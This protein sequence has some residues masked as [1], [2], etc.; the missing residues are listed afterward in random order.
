M[1]ASMGSRKIRVSSVRRPLR[2]T[3]LRTVHGIFSSCI[4]V[5]I[6]PSPS[7]AFG[8]SA[9]SGVPQH[10]GVDGLLGRIHPDHNEF[11]KYLGP[12]MAVN[13]GPSV[14]ACWTRQRMEMRCALGWSVAKARSTQTPRGLR[15]LVLEPQIDVASEATR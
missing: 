11:G 10:R 15:I 7:V 6:G 1:W 13:S 4:A 14:A 3:A 9:T 5:S 12:L 8:A 2:Q